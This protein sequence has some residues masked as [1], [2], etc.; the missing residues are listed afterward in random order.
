M[1]LAVTVISILISYLLSSFIV[2]RIFKKAKINEILAYIPIYNFIKLLSLVDFKWYYIFGFIISPVNI[3][4]WIY[5]NIKLGKKF[6]KSNAFIIGMIILP[7]IFYIILAF[8][9]DEYDF[10][11]DFDKK[12]FHLTT[13][14]V[15]M[16]TVAFVSTISIP[17]IFNNITK[18]L[19]LAGGFEI[20]YQVSSA[21]KKSKLTKEDLESAYKTMMRRIDKL[22][23]SEPEISIEGNDKIRV[24]LAGVTDPDEAR[25]YITVTGELTFRD[26]SDNKLMDKD[27]IS[28]AKI[29]Q[30]DSGNPAILLNVKNK[31][32][33]YEQT[34][35]ISQTEDQ[36]IVIW[37]DYDKSMGDS[38]KTADC[39]NFENENTV[40]CLSAATVRQG[41]SSNVII[42]GNFTYEQAK[43]LVDLINSGSSNVKYKEISSKTVTSAFGE[44]SLTKTE[45]AGVI[46]VSLI[47]VFLII[48]YRFSGFIS[49][50]SVLIY[51]CMT[52]LIFYLIDG[53]LT[54][55]GIAA[56]LLGIGMAVDACVITNERIKEELRKGRSLKTAFIN[57]NKNS[58]SS[59]LDSNITTLIIALVLFAF[60]ESSVKGF[61]TML[62]INLLM[63]MFI[64]ILI[65]RS[66]M[67]LFVNTDYFEGKE[68]AF[69]NFNKDK[70]IK[71]RKFSFVKNFTKR[72]IVPI[73]VFILGIIVTII[74]GVNL[75]VDFKGGSDI[76]IVS[77]K[78]LNEDTI[79]KDIKT[80]GY[81]ISDINLTNNNKTVYVKINE[82]LGKEK[83]KTTKHTFEEKYNA[84]TEISVVSNVVK[85]DLIKNTIIALIAA[86]LAIV[87]YISFRYKF[88]FA[89]SAL[90][91]LVHDILIMFSL[92]S[93][94]NLE[95]NTMLVVAIL[96]IV[97]YSI[98]N[99]IVIFDRIREN[100]G[101]SSKVKSKEELEIIVDNSVSQ[102]L[103]RSI[104]TT[105][106]TLIPI[107][108]LLIFGEKAIYEFNIAILFGLIAGFYSSVLLSS[109]I[110]YRI[111]LKSLNPKKNNKKKNNKKKK[112]EV[113]EL[114]ELLVKGINS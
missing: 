44:N 101:N 109:Q 50:L 103:F 3:W 83:I 29:S 68:K 97:G 73:T 90:I 20:L 105:I 39:G 95:I 11:V 78:T 72:L 56:L 111:E 27:V 52:L 58:F 69:V 114:D 13:T 4:L 76:S 92:F 75:G 91:A 24:K 43:S 84:K 28:G 85:R 74:T 113:K 112:K 59:I 96:T 108:V 64:I 32:L 80:L 106:T 81:T 102:T 65:N 70:K 62:I 86:F 21:D 82:V 49:S 53:V 54:L 57:G 23:V 14:L 55:T 61:A 25:N 45:I 60:G 110:W 22:G 12:G 88:S 19:D 46:G 33:F 30:D 16:I 66:I 42:Q 100:L 34:E 1:N 48:F 99:T 71:E 87:V 93:I 26:S 15:A 5:L 41:F 6:N 40:K 10:K 2:S 36:L 77:D 31:D 18:G 67:K 63:T 79:Q 107:I 51:S 89:I 104:N 9:K 17:Y 8:N 38:Y 35:K 47:I 98:N 94:F 7:I 37:L